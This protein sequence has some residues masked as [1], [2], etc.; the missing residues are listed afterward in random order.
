MWLECIIFGLKSY[1]WKCVLRNSSK[2]ENISLYKN[3]Y[4]FD[5]YD[6]EKGKI[7]L[8]FKS[9]KE[10]EMTKTI[11]KDIYTYVRENY[12]AVI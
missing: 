1:S 7:N 4:S 2:E 8:N 9:K 5:I 10:R 3:V 11:K 12:S 6:S